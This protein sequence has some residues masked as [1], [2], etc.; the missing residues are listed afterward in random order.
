MVLDVLAT[1]IRKIPAGSN[2]LA[3]LTHALLEVGALG[4]IDKVAEERLLSHA[5]SRAGQVR[6]SLSR[7]VVARMQATALPEAEIT[8][9]EKTLAIPSTPRAVSRAIKRIEAA[10]DVVLH[11]ARLRLEAQEKTSEFRQ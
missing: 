7:K 6:A 4:G 11:E 9:T 1:R 2:I 8:T 3:D 10:T 5:V